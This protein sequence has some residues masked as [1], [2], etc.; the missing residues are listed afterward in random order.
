MFA[1]PQ[2]NFPAQILI[3]K[4]KGKILSGMSIKFSFK[5]F[6]KKRR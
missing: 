1:S 5:K 4:S 6:M 2:P 3:A